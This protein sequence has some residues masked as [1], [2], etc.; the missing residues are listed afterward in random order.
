M[1][2]VLWLVRKALL[3]GREPHDE[4][5]FRIKHIHDYSVTYKAK[6]NHKAACCQL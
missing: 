5:V 3:T 1:I 2:T 6:Y 4:V